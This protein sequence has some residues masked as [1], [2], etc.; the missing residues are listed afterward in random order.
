[1]HFRKLLVTTPPAETTKNY[2]D[3]LL[4]FQIFLIYRVKF[5]YFVILSAPVLGFY[6]PRKILY[7]LQVLVY[8]LYR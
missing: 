5:S 4:S 3:N 7:Q 6:G 2:I 8:S 1:M